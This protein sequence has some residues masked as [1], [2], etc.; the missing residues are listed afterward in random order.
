MANENADPEILKRAAV[1]RLL[2]LDVDGVLTDGRI[3]YTADNVEVKSFHVRDGSA[4][5]FWQTVGGKTAIISGRTSGV[6]D[7]RAAELGIPLVLQGARDKRAA[8]QTVLKATG[9]M[10]MMRRSPSTMARVTIGKNLS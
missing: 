5:V 8:L 6:V 2:V 9:M 10:A 7:G 4:V 3:T 1:I